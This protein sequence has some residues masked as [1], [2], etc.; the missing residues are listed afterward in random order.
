[1][2]RISEEANVQPHL[3]SL[4]SHKHL[5]TNAARRSRACRES[6]LDRSVTANMNRC[7]LVVKRQRSLCGR[8]AGRRPSSSSASSS[9]S[10]T[11][12]PAKSEAIEGLLEQAKSLTHEERRAL[13]RRIASHDKLHESVKHGRAFAS[14][15]LNNGK[16]IAPLAFILTLWN[17]KSWNPF[18]WRDFQVRV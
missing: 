18:R 11:S 5:A 7:A 17:S 6:D 9:S 15:D 1:M 2:F 14:A 4:W 3:F 12:A 13:L 8:T 10:S 16:L